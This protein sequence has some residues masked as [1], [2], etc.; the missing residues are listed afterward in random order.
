M[1]STHCSS[2]EQKERKKLNNFLRI[3]GSDEGKNGRLLW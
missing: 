1:Y 2:F 3:S